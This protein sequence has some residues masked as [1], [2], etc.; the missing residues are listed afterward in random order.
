MSGA[1]GPHPTSTTAAIVVIRRCFISYN[2]NLL[3]TN[4]LILE[5]FLSHT[6][7]HNFLASTPKTYK[8]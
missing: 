4:G 3:I 6:F 5:R 8:S 1:F 7:G 2:S